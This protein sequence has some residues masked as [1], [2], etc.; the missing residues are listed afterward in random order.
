[1]APV[2]R[3]RTQSSDSG[4]DAQPPNGPTAMSKATARLSRTLTDLADSDPVHGKDAKALRDAAAQAIHEVWKDSKNSTALLVQKVNQGNTVGSKIDSLPMV[5]TFGPDGQLPRISPYT[6]SGD[7][8]TQFSIWLRRLEDVLRMRSPPLNSEQKANFLIGYLDGVAR[9]K[10]EELSPQQ[11]YMARQSLASCRQE[12]GESSTV[13]ANRLLNLVRAATTGQGAAIQKERA[14][15]EF[16][17]RL[18]SDIRYFVKL[19]NP[20]TFEQAVTKAQTVEQL[21]SEA[22]AERLINPAAAPTPIAVKAVAPQ[23]NWSR[24]SN[25]RPNY[26]RSAS[27]RDRQPRFQPRGRPQF[28]RPEQPRPQPT[29]CYNCGGQGHI[30][31]QCPSPRATIQGSTAITKMKGHLLGTVWISDSKEF[32]LSWHENSPRVHDCGNDLVVSDQGYALATVQRVPRPRSQSRVPPPT[33]AASLPMI[34]FPT[35]VEEDRALELAHVEFQAKEVWPPRAVMSP[36]N[37]LTI[38]RPGNFFVTQ[39]PI[40]VEGIPML[41]LVDTGAVITVTDRE[42]A[43]LLG[44]FKLEPSDIP[45]AIG[46][47]GVPVRLLGR[48]SLSFQIGATH[49]NHRV[50]ITD[51]ACIPSG[52]DSYNIILGNDV[53]A[54]LPCW[55]INYQSKTFSMGNENVRILTAS[56]G[57]NQPISVRVAQTTV[58]RPSSETFVPCY[59]DA[60]EDSTLVLTQQSDALTEKSL[61]KELDTHINKLLRAGRIKESDTPWVH[62]TVLVKK[63]DGSLRV[64]LD[65]RPLN[66]IT[67]PDYYPL[68]RIED[69]LTKIAGHKYYTTLDLA[70][71]YMQLLLS[72]ESQRKCGWATHRGHEI[73]GSSYSPA[74]RNIR[75]IKDFPTPT[76]IKEVKGFVGMANFFRKFIQNFS[77]I[78]APLYELMKDKAKFVWGTRQNEAFLRLKD[79]LSSKPC[80]AFPQDREFY[81][82]TDGS[83]LAVGAAL[84]QHKS[85]DDKQ[86][87]AIDHRPL[88]YLLTHNKTHDNL[89]RWVVEL[90]SYDISIRYLK[91]SS[92]VVADA[93]SRSSDKRVRFVDDT[94]DAEDIIEYPVSINLNFPT[95]CSVRTATIFTNSATAIRPYD[96][97]QEQLSDN[98]CSALISFIQTQRFPEHVSD[99]EKPSLI[100]IAEKCT[101]RKNGCLYFTDSRTNHSGMS[102]ERLVLPEKLREPVFLAFHSSPSAGGHFHWR[103]TLSKI[104]RKYYWP[105]MA[106]DIYQLCRSCD[107]CQRKRERSMNREKLLPVVTSAIFDKVYADLTGPIHT[108]ET[109]NK[110]ILA[111]ID[112]FS[113]YVIAV[114]IP[115]CTAVSVAHAIMTECILK[116]GVMVELVTDNA[117]YFKAELMTELGRLLRINPWKNARQYNDEQRKKFKKQHDKSH[118]EPLSIKVGDRVYLKDF[119]PK[120]GISQKLT[121]PW[122]GQFR[123][124][125]IDHPH[126]TIVS[127]SAP[128]SAPKRVHMN[129]VKKCFS[130]DGPVFTSP[131]LPEEENL[132]LTAAEASDEVIP[133]KRG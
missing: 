103:K 31:R 100:A 97:L 66:D 84:F 39:I 5:A 26:F 32:A 30:S 57:T 10:I 40:C 52:V 127:I 72:P 80:L 73:S 54:R 96:A 119:A 2:T 41:A 122:L 61:L 6:G 58:L 47:A 63:K 13:F 50:Y 18:R 70:S 101:I 112:H 42:V 27:P 98:F 36:T 51:S 120:V 14:L 132:A 59:S 65:F 45:T 68:P 34:E 102:I 38:T 11:R 76:T 115:D 116:Y 130:L 121:N 123:V 35:T 67:I 95:I 105:Q 48:A 23:N 125:Q 3:A 17:A 85:D 106:E 128:Q 114:P 111:L 83:Q 81:L 133:D 79:C 44:I 129:Q 28:R 113:K 109:G 12:P 69:I 99:A 87:V 62:N 15:E 118:L 29:T 90:Q 94:P 46:M 4:A 53:L 107:A 91:G 117:S 82:H 93:L 131:W 20:A 43:T 86:L 21:L 108:S 16:V 104:S 7:N 25:N 1:M 24:S 33:V 74:E 75:A 60:P 8:A 71:G 92:N 22:A 55:N 124:I 110:Y 126:L 64:C 77:L 88:T 9:E 49:L 56:P 19:D 37:V 78:A 89:A